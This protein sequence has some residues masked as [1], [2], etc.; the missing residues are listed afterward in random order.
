MAR[1]PLRNYRRRPARAR[2]ARKPK[3]TTVSAAVKKYVKKTLHT[4]IENKTQNVQAGANFGAYTS[5]ATMN[6]YPM[7]P[8]T[9]FWTISQGLTQN[10]R[11]GN[12]IKPVKVMLNYVIRPNGYDAI[13]NAGPIPMEVD[14]FLG[15]V[16]NC[17]SSTPVA[18]DFNSLLQG[19]NTSYPPIGN[20]TDIIATTNKDYWHIAKRWRHKVGYAYSDGQGNNATFQ[21]FSNNDFKLNAVRRLDITKFIPKTI[22]FND[23]GASAT[24]KGLFFFFQGVSAAGNILASTQLP[25]NIQYWIDFQYEDA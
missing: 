23:S 13:T 14:M 10:N 15:Y 18:S 16:K 7:C 17:P 6:I 3:V 12:I 1:K 24:T 20:L 9:G 22:T 21:F 4:Q 8:T 11:I 5:S 25:L 2:G 19:G